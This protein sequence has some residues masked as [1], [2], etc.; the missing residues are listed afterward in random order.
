IT[1]K[2]VDETD[3]GLIGA[4]VLVKGTTIGTITDFDGNYEL[5]V[6]QDATTLVFSYTGYSTQDIELG[7]SNVVNVTLSEGVALGEVVVTAI[8][9]EANR[10]QLGYSVQN[11]D[12]DEIVESNEANLVSALSAKVAG[13]N[14]TSSSGSPG[15]SAN[16][17]IRGATSI[18]RSNS[19]L[20]VIDGVPISNAESGSPDG[21]T[22]GVDQSNRAI[23]INPN[24]IASVSVLKGPAATA[25]YGLRAANGAIVIQTKRGKEGKAKVQASVTYTASEPNKLPELQNGF[26]QGRPTATD[27]DGDGDTDSFTRT[28]RSPATAEGFSWGPA[29]GDLAY[30]PNV[31]NPYD[32]N[33][34]IVPGSSGINTYDPYSFFVTGQNVDANVSIS[35]GTDRINYY[36]SSGFLNSQGIVPNADFQRASL[37]ATTTAKLTDKLTA[38]LSAN[39]VNS[40]GTRIQRGS[41]LRGVML[42]LLRTS[43]SFDNG[44][45]LVGQE[46]ADLE[47]TYL[48]PNGTQRSYRAGVYDNPYWTV[49]KNPYED[50]VN[51]V[52]GF[53]SL[54]YQLTDWASISYKLGLDTYTDQRNFA[55]DINPSPFGGNW[56]DG[57]VNVRNIQRRDLN[58]DLLLNINR[59]L[60]D[61]LSISAV[62]G[63][64]FYGTRT[65][66]DRIDGTTLSIT[67][68]Y[69]LKNASDVVVDQVISRKKIAAVFA[70]ADVNFRDYLFF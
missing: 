13:V 69:N 15:S 31:A 38:T 48:L 64:N 34:A 39:Y 41:N 40:G 62:I 22:A 9:L 14:V 28:Y 52:L 45:G 1:G 66:D 65:V 7:A 55:Q 47:S 29:V 46:A 36:F 30:D 33:G 4:S 26:A 20:F 60:S 44:N 50:N 51:R 42:G 58:S 70:T 6:P 67:G 56:N 59:S 54:N 53:A 35:G 3:E 21:S 61:D 37:K 24:D 10:S 23:D 12:T 8:G 5:S 27:T 19:P 49:N 16:I 57:S 43:P 63:H 18:N 2:I 68:F 25:L 17:R 32:Q 11:V